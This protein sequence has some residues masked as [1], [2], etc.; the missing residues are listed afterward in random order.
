[1]KRAKYFTMALFLVF[2]ISSSYALAFSGTVDNEE[3]ILVSDNGNGSF[4]L[5]TNFANLV[6]RNAS[7]VYSIV[8]S[9]IDD[10]YVFA[11]NYAN[12]L[13]RVNEETFLSVD[14]VSADMDSSENIEQ[15]TE[16]HQLPQEISGYLYSIYEAVENQEVYLPEGRVILYAPSNFG[17]SEGAEYV[18]YN[19]CRYKD[20]LISEHY[21]SEWLHITDFEEKTV[22]EVNKVTAKILVETFVD[23]VGKEI[24][25]YMSSLADVLDAVT[26]IK[27]E[28][29]DKLMYNVQAMVIKNTKFTAIAN[30]YAGYA[31]QIKAQSDHV[32]YKWM[33]EVSDPVSQSAEIVDVDNYHII[34]LDNYTSLDTKA[35]QWSDLMSFYIEEVEWIHYDTFCHFNVPVHRPSD[36]IP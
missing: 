30:P 20:Y 32:Q 2:T 12:K 14:E 26:G 7:P 36:V 9:E 18:G 17:Y 35:F 8:P 4:S 5:T 25:G 23:S 13:L 24:L 22:A 34:T 16:E 11:D 29:T 3:N 1:M 27:V 28:M 15:V 33:Y 10:I 21:A 31:F 6:Q 19:N